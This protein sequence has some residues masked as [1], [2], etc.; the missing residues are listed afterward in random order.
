MPLKVLL[1]ESGSKDSHSVEPDLL[2]RGDEVVVTHIPRKVP[3]LAMAEWPDLIVVN[4]CAGA[5]TSGKVVGGEK[6]K[7]IKLWM[8]EFHCFANL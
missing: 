3:S 8:V 4:V 7:L 6:M 2:K 1:V 5:L